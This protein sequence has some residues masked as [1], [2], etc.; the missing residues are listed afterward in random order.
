MGDSMTHHRY[1]NLCS[2]IYYDI[3]MIVGALS[4]KTDDRCIIIY[5]LH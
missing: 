2:G 1:S 3:Y 5:N 4:N